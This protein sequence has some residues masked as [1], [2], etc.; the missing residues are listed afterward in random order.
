MKCL[1]R[2]EITTDQIYSCTVDNGANM[3][4]MVREIA[5][6]NQLDN[7]NSENSDSGSYLYIFFSIIY[8]VFIFYAKICI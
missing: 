6:I 3:V 2:Y 7:D 4:K 8:D 5:E 1:D